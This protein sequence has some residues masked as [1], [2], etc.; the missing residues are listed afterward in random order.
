MNFIIQ[1]ILKTVAGRIVTGLLI[2]SLLGG[3]AWKWYSFKEGLKDEGQAECIQ[4]VNEET[5]QKLKEALAA[6]QAAN[7]DLLERIAIAKAANQEATERRRALET[8]VGDL[9]KAMADQARTDNEYKN[10]SV[11]PLPDGIA[12]RLR[13]MQAGVDPGSVREDSN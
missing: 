2:T 6:A 13:R 12:D 5:H 3:V 10:W 11:A 8:Q 1:W 9:E 4:L 7:T